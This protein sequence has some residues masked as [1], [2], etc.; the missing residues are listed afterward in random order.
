VVIRPARTSVSTPSSV[1]RAILLGASNVDRGLPTV[2]ETALL[3]GGGPLELFLACGR[4]RSYGIES[5]F[6]G[7][8]LPGITECGLWQALASRPAMPTSALLTDIGNDLL[9]EVPVRQ[10]A[11]WVEA[12]LDRLLAMQARPVITALPLAN[13][14]G[15]SPARFKFFRTMFFRRCGLSLE[16]V[17]DATRQLDEQIQQIAR[18][19]GV[20]LIDP[21][22][23]WYG[24]DPIHIRFGS[25]PAAWCEILAPWN[26]G[27]PLQGRPMSWL[28]WCRMQRLKPE[29]CWV[30]GIERQ[31]TQPALRCA[32]GTTVWLY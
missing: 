24:F 15:L 12:C 1:R 30:R 23:T 32:D 11:G 25:V 21:R 2:V 3:C 27:A 7:R 16:Q 29:R 4:G 5:R 28:A 10:I 14:A 18:A 19:R 8:V 31:T 6:M 13:V 20:P 17:S 26:T 9:Y 22:S